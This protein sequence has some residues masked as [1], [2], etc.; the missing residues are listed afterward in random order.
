MS[1]T[2]SKAFHSYNNTPTRPEFSKPVFREKIEIPI[3]QNK[4]GETVLIPTVEDWLKENKSEEK[5][6]FQKIKNIFKRN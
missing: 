6:F 4:T 2:T 1:N 3:I 5:T